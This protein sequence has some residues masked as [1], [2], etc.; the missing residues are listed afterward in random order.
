MKTSGQ[1]KYNKPP[2]QKKGR[3]RT[4]NEYDSQEEYALWI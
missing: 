3:K 4:K 2:P 1:I